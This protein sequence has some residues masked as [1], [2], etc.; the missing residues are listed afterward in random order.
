MCYKTTKVSSVLVK[1]SANLLSFL[2]TQLKLQ[3]IQFMT[4]LIFSK[5]NV[6]VQKL[7]S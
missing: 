7:E 5:L 4:R 6:G 1:G 2:T 3:Y